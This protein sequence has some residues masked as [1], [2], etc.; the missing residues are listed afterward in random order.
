MRKPGY[1]ETG[2]EYHVTARINRGEFALETKEIKELFLQTV[3]RA[4][5]KYSF[6]LKSFVIMDNHIHLL[7]KPGKGENLSKIMQWILSV[8]AKCHNK[9]FNLNGHVWSDRFKSKIIESFK[10]LISTF[11]YICNNPVKA[12]MAG[13]AEEY[14]YGALW[15]IRHSIMSPEFKTE[16]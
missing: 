11:K 3:K 8:F 1:L 5:E 6:K 2:A 13:N 9:H 16:I 12:E 10:Q 7:I 15:F 4:K 14:L